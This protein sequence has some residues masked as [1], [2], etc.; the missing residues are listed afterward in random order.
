MKINNPKYVCSKCS[1][2]SKLKQDV[3]DKEKERK[4]CSY[5]KKKRCC[6]SIDS[7]A[8]AVD[9]MYRGNY[10]QCNTGCSP[11]EIISDLLEL[12]QSAGKLDADLVN[13]LFNRELH[14]V[15]KGVDPI[16]DEDLTYCSLCEKYPPIKDGREHK[17]LWDTFCDKIKHRTRYFNSP[18]IEWLN[19]IFIGLD[20]ISYVDNKL[21]I[22][23][24]SPNDS[25]SFFYR[26]RHASSTNA[27]M[28]ICCHPTQEL[29]SPPVQIAT[30]GRMNPI[31]VSVFYA[32][33]DRETCIAELRLP[34]GEEAI[35]GQFKLELPITVL[36]L[37]VLD[38]IDTENAINNIVEVP[39]ENDDT[40]SYEDRL[41]FLQKFSSE[42]SKPI[43]PDKQHLDYMPTQAF[44]EY[45]AHHYKPKIDAVIYSSTQTNG[46]GKNIVF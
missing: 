25:E 45:L 4:T 43:S 5:C 11:S 24:L 3:F 9:D 1:G 44:A 20:K 33:F 29:N 36:D 40:D 18:V 39:S 31:G 41:A 21:A 38:N 23:S 42:I 8:D 2:N 17:E 30:G 14:G 26:A 27:R 32:A 16:Y 7:L 28:K 15:D 37:T 19:G 46:K 22:R 10:E 6:I 35:S 12:D 13:I 34:V